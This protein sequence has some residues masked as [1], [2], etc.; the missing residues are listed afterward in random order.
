[1]RY[2][3]ALIRLTIDVPDTEDTRQWMALFK[4]ELLHRF[5]QLEIYVV[6]FTL[7]VL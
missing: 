2:D 5:D 7:E 6:A 1:M 4:S 3:D